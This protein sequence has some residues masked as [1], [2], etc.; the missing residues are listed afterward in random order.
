MM[1]K[2]PDITSIGNPLMERPRMSFVSQDNATH[3][4]LKAAA[5]LAEM[6]NNIDLTEPI[7][8]G[9]LVEMFRASARVEARADVLRSLI[10]GDY[11]DRDRTSEKRLL[12]TRPVTFKAGD[13]V[14][15]TIDSVP[16]VIQEGD[17]GSGYAFVRWNDGSSLFAVRT[18]LLVAASD[19]PTD[20]ITPIA[21]KSPAA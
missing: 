20:N 6:V 12:T 19:I 5:D 10:G 13:R 16:G 7:T 18:C 21:I 1:G 3:D 11:R 2:V 4:L 8:L 17:A 14:L 9:D 15:R